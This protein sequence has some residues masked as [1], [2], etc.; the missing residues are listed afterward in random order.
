MQNRITILE[1][2]NKVYGSSYHS[3]VIKGT[4]NEI[5]R[6]L[7][8]KP[9]NLLKKKGTDGKTKYEWVLL[10]DNKFPFTI[11]D[12]SGDECEPVGPNEYYEY[13]LGWTPASW[14]HN[15]S[16]FRVPDTEDAWEL[17]QYLREIGLNADHSK[18]WYA[19]NGPKYGATDWEELF[20]LK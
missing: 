17:I 18:S 10:F 5:I 11:Y 16:S 19:W 14:N 8:I 7:G 20:K 13:H 1:E 3:W 12:M 2:H 15:D 9:E 4:K 6:K